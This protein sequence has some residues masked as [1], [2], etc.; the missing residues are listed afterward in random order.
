MKNVKNIVRDRVW[1]CTWED[2]SNHIWF[3]V[4]DLVLN[5]IWDREK[6]RIL[7]HLDEKVTP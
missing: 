3:H 1:E 5:R 6:N 2:V 7:D 4:S